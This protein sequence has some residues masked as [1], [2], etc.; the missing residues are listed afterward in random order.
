M[1][2]AVCVPISWDKVPTEFLISFSRMFRPEQ[3]N[4]MER[5]GVKKFWQLFNRVF[6]LDLN[7]NRLVKKSL[8][9]KADLVLFLDADMTFPS[10]LIPRLIEDMKE[11]GPCVIS[12][13]YF[14]KAPPFPPVSANRIFS[15]DEQK[16]FPIELFK[17]ND[18]PLAECDVVGMGAALIAREVLEAVN[19]PWFE[20][21]VYKRTGEMTVTEDVPFCRKVKEAGFKIYTDKR[22]ECGHVTTFTVTGRHW[23][24]QRER[25]IEGTA[26]A[27][28]SWFC[29]GDGTREF[30]GQT[31]DKR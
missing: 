2:L 11:L 14:K 20:Y 15:N 13:L 8:E 16:M 18:S 5:L 31:N 9:L 24:E 30:K 7:R 28:A 4:E 29:S 26:C 17:A 27:I 23:R 19:Q 22:L 3:L 25:L 21:G 12:G 6:P 10:D 1:N